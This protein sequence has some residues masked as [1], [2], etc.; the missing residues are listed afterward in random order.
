VRVLEEPRVR[1]TLDGRSRLR[2]L[3]FTSAQ[4][5]TCGRVYR[6]AGQ[7]RRIRDDRGRPR[8]VARTVLLEGV[9]C[10]GTG[11]EPTGCGRHCP[12]WYRDEWLEPATAPRQ[13][14]P[15]PSTAGHARVRDLDEIRSGLD[16]F[17][18][19]DGLSFM[20]EM[21]TLAGR[22]YRIRLRLGPVFECDRFVP[23]RSAI[24]L[25]EGASCS[26]AAAGA[27]GPCHRACPLLWHEDWLSLQP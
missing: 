2:G 16:L 26:G 15:A 18:R 20:P 6:V 3:L 22:H 4:T 12:T 9:N 23:T 5:E 10:T 27:A 24:Y 19:H 13:V 17:G 14:P 21:A 7:V 11:V 25:L 1:A 8:P